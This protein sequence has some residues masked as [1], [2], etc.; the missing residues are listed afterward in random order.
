MKMI[1]AALFLA[2]AYLLPFVTGQIPRIGKMFCPMHIPVLLCGFLCGW[3]WGAAVG[4]VAPLLRSLTLGVPLFFPQAVAMAFELAAYGAV[5][6]FVYCRMGRK[7]WHL[8]ATL[9]IAMV[10]GRLIWGSTMVICMGLGGAHFGWFAFLSGAVFQAIPGIV[11]Q[12]I[13]IPL[14]VR[15]CERFVPME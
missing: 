9:L 6:G 13:L 11:S 1:L 2:V 7:T 15:A 14:L 10:I 4:F 5:A 12:I 8:Y 3:G